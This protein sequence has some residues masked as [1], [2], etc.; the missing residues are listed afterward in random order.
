MIPNVEITKIDGSL[1]VSPATDR[2][3][4]IVGVSSSG[5]VNEPTAI[6][7]PADAVSAFGIGP[8]V[9]A[10]AYAVANG[11]PCVAVR[12]A[13]GT[14]GAYGAIT[15]DANGGDLT[16]AASASVKPFESYRV[17]VEFLTGGTVGV[18]GISY[19]ASVD[20]G[21]TWSGS[22]ALGTAVAI[23]IGSDL[24]F[25]LTADDEIVAG[26]SFS[27]DCTG[28]AAGVSNIGSALESLAGYP[29]SYTRVLT[30][31]PVDSTAISALDSW[32]RSRWIDGQY[33]EV[34]CGVRP[35]GA[36]ETRPV[37]LSAMNAIRVD[38]S[39]LEVSVCYDACE[40]ASVVPGTVG[41]RHVRSPAL[42][43]AVRTVR[44]ADATDAAETGLGALPGVFL[45]SNERFE[46]HDERRW[47]GADDLHFTSLRTW[48]AKPG[49]Y[50]NN[51]RVFS[52]QSSDFQWFQNTSVL[53]RA[54]TMTHA[55][56]INE[57]SKGG[58]V[59]EET[60]A[61]ADE[62][63]TRIEDTVNALVTTQFCSVEKQATNARVKLSTGDQILKNG[64]VVHFD[65]QVV[66]LGYV[67]K[68]IGKGALVLKIGG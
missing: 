40:V 5:E 58:P 57:L 55:A 7:T 13:T 53:N 26:A 25:S 68:F 30:L 41:R 42:P 14:A 49:A 44:Y 61:L 50:V 10:A 20:A 18:A 63:I 52:P 65:V 9:E 48:S 21:A 66:P 24:S 6:T 67:K 45:R 16:V 37:Y 35:R 32:A 27:C 34:I 2:T 38:V 28:A 31:D 43:F 33:P 4:A 51:P 56:L 59:N 54:H 11:V 47:P 62:Y 1:G 60:G 23:A 39:S 15:V 12:A 19:R 46:Y 64:G 17:R 8:L 29:A 36:A 22:Q 3:L